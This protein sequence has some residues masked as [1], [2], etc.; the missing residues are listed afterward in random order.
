MENVRS[1]AVILIAGVVVAAILAFLLQLPG[2]SI[3]TLL[4]GERTVG[5]G[6]F[7][8]LEMIAGALT[9]LIITGI[10]VLL[11]RRLMLWVAAISVAIQLASMAFTQSYHMPADSVAEIM[12]RSAEVIGIV[13]GA[14]I[15]VLVARGLFTARQKPAAS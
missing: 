7:W 12:F 9:S 8:L 13:A 10:A 4:V 3:R 2:L 5:G 15:A 1:N 11:L 6:Q 14:V